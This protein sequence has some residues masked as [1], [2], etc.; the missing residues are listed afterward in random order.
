VSLIAI[1]VVA[2][3]AIFSSLTAPLILQHRIERMHRE[4]Q[5]AQFD[6]DDAL[7]ARA[8]QVAATLKAQQDQQAEVARQVADRLQ[9]AQ[10]ETI[11]RTNEVAHT[12]R[13]TAAISNAKLDV[14]HG[15]V[16]STMTA[17]M[18]SELD[19][20]KASLAMMQEVLDL[21]QS[22]GHPPTDEVL[23]AITLTKAKIASLT[24]VISDR[25]ATAERAAEA[26]DRTE[27]E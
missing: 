24:G 18:A 17:A 16:N 14:I 13:E 2:L 21:K 27:R 12:A 20:L 25:V 9:F 7:R 3:I 6:R 22:M 8:E 19:A 1:L 5:K 15:L 26:A 23:N 4:D 11:R 10:A